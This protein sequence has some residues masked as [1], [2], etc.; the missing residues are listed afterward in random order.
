MRQVTF[1]LF[2]SDIS[3]R[4]CSTVVCSELQTTNYC[5]RTEH[6]NVENSSDSRVIDFYRLKSNEKKKT[7][8]TLVS[9]RARKITTDYFSLSEGKR[10]KSLCN[11]SVVFDPIRD[12]GRFPPPRP[13]ACWFFISSDGWNFDGPDE[14]IFSLR[15]RQISLLISVHII[16]VDRLLGLFAR[17]GTAVGLSRNRVLCGIIFIPPPP[18]PLF[19]GRNLCLFT[20]LL[21]LVVV[22]FFFFYSLNSNSH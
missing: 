7:I 1:N 19:R 2:S 5:S 4:L 14:I 15:I 6:R 16:Y 13:R 20:V 8:C 11:L 17:R 21:L 10:E 12:C 18:I 3:K 22:F 9:R